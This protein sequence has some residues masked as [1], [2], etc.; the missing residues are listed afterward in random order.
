[1]RRKLTNRIRRAFRSEEGFTLLELMVVVVIIAILA[2]GGLVGY[3][4]FIQ[5]AVDAVA[6]STGGTL[7]TAVR[8]YEVENG[9]SLA[10]EDVTD[11]QSELAKYTQVTPKV[12]G[13]AVQGY[14][15]KPADPSKDEM[16]IQCPG[17][18]SKQWTVWVERNGRVGKATFQGELAATDTGCAAATQSD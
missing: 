16:W 4:A 6:T 8:M 3:N 1:M 2:A 14:T 7:A 17:K 10:D 11:V 13:G 18:D 9:K 15:P 5:R 12:V